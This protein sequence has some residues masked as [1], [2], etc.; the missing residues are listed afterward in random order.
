MKPGAV[1]EKKAFTLTKTT[2][3]KVEAEVGLADEKVE[4]GEDCL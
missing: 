3:R 1:E 2:E 4:R